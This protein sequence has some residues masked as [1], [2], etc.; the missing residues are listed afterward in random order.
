MGHSYLPFSQSAIL[1]N[2]ADSDSIGNAE[3]QEI[4]ALLPLH[5]EL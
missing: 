1:E 5:I 2:L 4:Y 3:E